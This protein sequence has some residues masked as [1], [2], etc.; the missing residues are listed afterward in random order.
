MM[1]NVKQAIVNKLL[2]LYPTNKIYDEDLP[3]DFIKPYFLITLTNQDYHKRLNN[4]YKSSISFDISYY[5]SKATS[6]IKADFLDVQLNL[7][8]L[9]DSVGTYRVLNKQATIKDNALHF[10]FNINYSEIKEEANTLIQKQQTNTN[11]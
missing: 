5:S 3:Q 7:L 11:L 1:S 6:E 4:K 8:R 9:L 2:E 10:T